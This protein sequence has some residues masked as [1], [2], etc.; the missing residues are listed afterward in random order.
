MRFFLIF[1]STIC[2]NCLADLSCQKICYWEFSNRTYGDIFLLNFPTKFC[3]FCYIGAVRIS[4]NFNYR[5]LL[6]PKIYHSFMVTSPTSFLLHSQK[7]KPHNFEVIE[8]ISRVLYDIFFIAETRKCFKKTFLKFRARFNDRVDFALV[9]FL[10]GVDVI[11]RIF[12][13]YSNY[14]YRT[15]HK[16]WN[17][18]RNNTSACPD[19]WPFGSIWA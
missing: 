13:N 2:W 1:S 15:V 18:Y 16:F 5:T 14:L 6:P 3:Y 4:K 10:F 7:K 9:R 17:M 11:V 12:M 19:A 8:H